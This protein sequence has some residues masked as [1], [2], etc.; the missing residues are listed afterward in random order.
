MIVRHVAK[1]DVGGDS[2]YAVKRLI[3]GVCSSRDAA[4]QGFASCLAEVLQVL[5]KDAVSN[6]NVEFDSVTSD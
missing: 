1:S 6:W 5:P 2:T 3:R 4:R